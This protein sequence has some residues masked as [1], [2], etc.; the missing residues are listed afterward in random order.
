MCVCVCVSE[1]VHVSISMLCML[2]QYFK[3]VVTLQAPAHTTSVTVSTT[4]P[5]FSANKF[6]FYALKDRHFFLSLFC[7]HLSLSLLSCSHHFIS[8][9][10]QHCLLSAMSLLFIISSLHHLNH[11]SSSRES[12][13]VVNCKLESAKGFYK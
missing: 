13:S 12:Y 5:Q 11:R 10:L 7:S 4:S 3:P 6:H 2:T 1:C 8:I 9:N